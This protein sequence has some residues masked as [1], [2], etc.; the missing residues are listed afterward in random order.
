VFK[1]EKLLAAAASQD[2]L[3]FGVRELVKLAFSRAPLGSHVDLVS[4]LVLSFSVKMS[5]F[6]FFDRVWFDLS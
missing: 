2:I 4:I 6:S 1:Y 3:D 5:M